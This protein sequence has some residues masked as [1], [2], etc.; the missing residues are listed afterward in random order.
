MC[1]TTTFLYT[2]SMDERQ[3]QAGEAIH[4]LRIKVG[5]ETFAALSDAEKQSI[6]FFIWAGCCMHKELNAAKGGNTKMWSWWGQKGI[7]GPVLLM[8]KDNAANVVLGSS[9]GKERAVTI[10]TGGGSEGSR[11][12]WLCVSTQ[13]RQTWSAKFISLLL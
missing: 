4:Q 7:K 6:D 13:G 5:E 10:S 3:I 1:A 11:S 2:L 8:N 12:R 9:K